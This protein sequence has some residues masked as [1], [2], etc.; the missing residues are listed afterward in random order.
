[1]RRNTLSESQADH[2]VK[3]PKFIEGQ[4]TW[5]LRADRNLYTEMPVKAGEQLPLQL[6]GR[7]NPR[8]G[9]SPSSFSTTE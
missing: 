3:L 1:M 6:Y 4:N 5:E 9:I 7:L 2:I 8:T